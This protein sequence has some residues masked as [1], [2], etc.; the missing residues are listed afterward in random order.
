MAQDPSGPASAESSSAVP[1]SAYLSLKAELTERNLARVDL[2][3]KESLE[4]DDGIPEGLDGDSPSNVERVP[5]YEGPPHTNHPFRIANND[6]TW[7]TRVRVDARVKPYKGMGKVP[8]QSET[9]RYCTS[10]PT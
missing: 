6:G 5:P 3:L 9:P 1:L 8:L 4:D 10:W 2:L 7:D